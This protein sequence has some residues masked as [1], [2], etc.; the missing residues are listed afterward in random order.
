M[1]PAD[2]QVAVVAALVVSAGTT[3]VVTLLLAGMG[4]LEFNPTSMEPR[5]FS[6]AAAVDIPNMLL[7]I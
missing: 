1:G 7:M 4:V 3:L 6:A 2:T 5:C